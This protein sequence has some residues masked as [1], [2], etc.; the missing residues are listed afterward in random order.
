MTL[1]DRV[2]AGFGPEDTAQYQI[3]QY[4]SL[5]GIPVFHVPNS[6]WTKSP[7]VRM[8]NLLLGVQPGVSD[9]FHPLPNIGMVIIELK[10]PRI[11]GQPRGR[12]SVEQHYWIKLFNT[13]PGTQAFV[14]E[15][16]DEWLGIMKPYIAA[17][18][19][20]PVESLIF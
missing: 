6:T 7:M 14:A 1:I 8:K 4:C 18:P 3:I 2:I 11:K 9:L 17:L 15:G 19:K 16:F 13:V 20:L 10:R 12:V 5:H